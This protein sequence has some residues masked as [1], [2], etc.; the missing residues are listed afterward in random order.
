LYDCDGPAFLSRVGD[1]SPRKASPVHAVYNDDPLLDNL[2]FNSP[3]TAKG[4][5]RSDSRLQS[6]AQ[7]PVGSADAGISQV[8]ACKTDKHEHLANQ[9]CREALFTQR[10]SLFLIFTNLHG[11]P[12]GMRKKGFGFYLDTIHYD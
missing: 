10:Q 1:L 5:C 2:R 11:T 6:C 7:R 8:A 3:E 9:G 4:F 12:R